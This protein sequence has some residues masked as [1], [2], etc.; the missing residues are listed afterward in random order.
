M[1]QAAKQQAKQQAEESRLALAEKQAEE[2][3]LVVAE[4]QPLSRLAATE[5]QAAN[6]I[7]TIP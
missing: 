6:R 4:I 3:R 5:K 7:Q 2:S 1:E